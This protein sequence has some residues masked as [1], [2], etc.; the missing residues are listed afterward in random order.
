MTNAPIG[1]TRV[2]RP[3]PN[4]TR[5]SG[6]DQMNRKTIQATRNSPPPFCDAM[7]GNRQMLPVPTA[8]PSMVSIMARREEKCCG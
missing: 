4:S 6:M 1:P 8:M 5:M 3:S 2:S 7:R